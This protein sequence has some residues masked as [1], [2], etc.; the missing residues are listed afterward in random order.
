MIQCCK[1]PMHVAIACG[2]TGGHFFPGLAV[3]GKLLERG[4]DVTLLV[5]PKEVDQQAV[6]DCRFKIVTLPALGLKRGGELA[7]LSGFFRSFRAS[8]KLFGAA[9]PDAVLAM[10]GF[11][12]APPVIAA[13][14]RGAK[15][16]LHESNTIPGRANR[17]LSWLVDHSFVGFAAASARLFHS[18]TSVTGTPVRPE[19]GRQ[20]AARCRAELGLEL[21]RPVVLVMGGSQG[22][23]AINDLVVQSLPL[24]ARS[25]REWQWFHL[26]GP[27]AAPGLRQ[28]YAESKLSAVVH[29][30]FDRMDLALG[31]ASA[32]ITRAGAST[33]AELAATKV[34]SLLVPFPAATGNHQFHNAR[35]YTTTGAARLLE[36]KEATPQLVTENMLDLVRN[37]SVRSTMQAA[38]TRWEMP[39]A[40]ERIAVKMLDWVQA[41]PSA[42]PL[43]LEPVAARASNQAFSSR[44]V[45]PGNF[46]ASMPAAQRS[47]EEAASI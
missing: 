6:K 29:P 27:E 7:F 16:F 19:F 34:P 26:A 44:T 39:G 31:A 35:A 14:L 5:S 11:T 8:S 3:A 40:A 23:K 2:G 18:R 38:L 47:G 37:S 1:V 33:L 45:A 21:G 24:F 36:Q 9:R 15:T 28:A 4:C 20:E 22:A 25:A 32:A 12:G 17:W 30:F 46:L 43:L 42:R 41:T 13:K 10:G